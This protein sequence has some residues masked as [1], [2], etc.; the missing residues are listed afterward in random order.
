MRARRLMRYLGVATMTALVGGVL[1]A[2]ATPAAADYQEGQF[3]MGGDLGM[4]QEVEG[5]GGEFT[6][7]GVD[8]V[9]LVRIGP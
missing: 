8:D 4:L 2:G 9:R 3:I 7:N 5:L 1:V 6:Q